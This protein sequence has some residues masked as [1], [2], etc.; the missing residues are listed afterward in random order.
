ME[1]YEAKGVFE[2]ELD[3]FLKRHDKNPLIPQNYG[4]VL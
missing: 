4:E 1:F 2:K 3:T